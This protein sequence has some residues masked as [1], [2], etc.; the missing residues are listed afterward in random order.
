M[1]MK[2]FLRIAG[3]SAG[4]IILGF[5]LSIF[6]LLLMVDLDNIN[7][8]SGGNQEAVPAAAAE[9]NEYPVNP[10]PL[11]LLELPEREGP[12]ELPINGATGWAGV[13][14]PLRNYPDDTAFFAR[15][16]TAGTAF[17]IVQ[18]YE[19]WWYIYLFGGDSG[20][21]RHEACFINLPD[22]IPSIIYNISNAAISVKVSSGYGIPTITGRQLYHA[23][24][25]NSRLDR[26]EFIVPI[27][28]STAFKVYAAQQ[29]ALNDGNALVIYEAFRPR[30]TQRAVAENLRVLMSS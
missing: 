17:T 9:N 7:L 8:F 25:F 20:W 23:R 5:S 1:D 24:S 15:A 18:E 28:Y 29:N 3:I 11:P 10:E 30:S 16:L 26:E 14:I 2:R 13:S 21:V 22:I 4:G 19:D 12:F 6:I 27:L